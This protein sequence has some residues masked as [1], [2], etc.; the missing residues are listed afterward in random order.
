M[1]R[2]P[3]QATRFQRLQA[4][5]SRLLLDW[6]RGSW[7]RGS[8]AL[9]ALL[10]GLYAGN[11]LTS[12]FLFRIG[13]RPLAVLGMVVLVELVIRLRSRFLKGE[14]GLGWVIC[15]NFRIGIVYAVVLEGFKL[16]S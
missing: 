11:N 16:G 14:P 12:F 10:I 13:Q 4:E 5:V 7:R 6:L 9:L 1:T 15:D 2:Q 3:F 8:A